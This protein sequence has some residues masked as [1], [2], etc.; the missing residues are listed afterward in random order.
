MKQQRACY[1]LISIIRRF[2]ERS[3][4]CGTQ[5]LNLC[6]ANSLVHPSEPQLPLV[7]RSDPRPNVGFASTATRAVGITI[8]P[9]RLRFVWCFSHT[10]WHRIE[11][12]L[13][14]LVNH[15]FR[16]RWGLWSCF[17]RCASMYDNAFQFRVFL[18]YLS[19]IWLTWSRG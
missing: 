3:H 17:F 10:F 13:V 12:F 2:R 5:T 14:N 1:L 8:S 16:S 19:S 4:A 6:L 11:V 7:L 9:A 15:R 18:S